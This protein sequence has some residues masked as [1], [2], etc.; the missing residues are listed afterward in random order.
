[1]RSGSAHRIR[2]KNGIVQLTVISL[3]DI[4]TILLLFLLVQLG[5]EGMALPA[6]DQLQLPSSTAQALPRSTIQM[7]V[8]GKDIVIEGRPVMTVKEAL[9]EKGLIL[10][11]V[12]EA[13]GRLTERTRFLASKNTSVH[14]T[15]NITLLGD[16]KIPFKLLKKLMNTSAEAGYPNISLGVVRQETPA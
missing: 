4:F 7:M 2:R 14:F 9:E 11:P 1:M 16:K 10:S 13:L 3:M 8:T 6:D 15:G 5:D 12:L